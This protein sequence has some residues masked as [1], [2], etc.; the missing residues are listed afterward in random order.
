ML[1]KR[2]DGQRGTE[3]DEDCSFD[4]NKLRGAGEK[5]QAESV[6]RINKYPTKKKLV[7]TTKNENGD[8]N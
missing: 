1:S 3:K 2:A 6:G 4:R 5:G 7:G 8:G